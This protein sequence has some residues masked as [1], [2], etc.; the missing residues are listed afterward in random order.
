MPRFEIWSVGEIGWVMGGAQL[1]GHIQLPI[2]FPHHFQ[3]HSWTPLIT[4][5]PSLLLPTSHMGTSDHPHFPITSDFTPG[6]F[7]LPTKLCHHPKFHTR[8]HAI[9]HL[10]SPPFPMSHLGTS[11]YP[12]TFIT[13]CNVTLGHI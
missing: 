9:T 11:N 10:I 4:H 8:L 13:T 6:H 5:P 12:A 3:F 2:H 7:P 1:S